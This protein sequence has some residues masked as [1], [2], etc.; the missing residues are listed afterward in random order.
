MFAWSVVLGGLGLWQI[1]CF[2]WDWP[3]WRVLATFVP[4]FALEALFVA[5]NS[6]KIPNGGWFPTGFAAMWY[7]VLP[8]WKRG[9]TLVNR[10][11]RSSGIEL[12][13]FFKEPAGVPPRCLWKARRCS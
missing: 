8:P 10:Q 5:A 12:E 6:A 2:K 9:G 11:L 4:L 7:F 3:A 13:P 1:V